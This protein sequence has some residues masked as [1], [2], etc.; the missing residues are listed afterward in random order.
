MIPH[1]GKTPAQR[2]VLDEIG[3]GNYSPAMA[4][5]TRRALLAAGLIVQMSDKILP[6]RF[7]VRIPEFQMPLRVHFR[8]CL[9]CSGAQEFP[10][11]STSEEVAQ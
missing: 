1:P 2:R 9:S 8:W 10:P 3:C 7:P 6:G 5:S 4:L 11:N